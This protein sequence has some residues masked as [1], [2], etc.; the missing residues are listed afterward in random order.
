MPICRL[1]NKERELRESHIVP[2]FMYAELKNNNRQIL[3]INGS[4]KRGRTLV[5]DGAKEHLFCEDCE[6]HFNKH[7]ETPFR[8]YWIETPPLPD[9]W[10]DDNPRWIATDY[11]PFKLFHLSILFRASVSTLPIFNP[12][13]LG[14]H[15]E[16]IRLLLLNCDPG[17]Y[18]EYPIA[19]YAVVHHTT[20]QLVKMIS[21]PQV[22]R[23]GGKQCYSIMYGG[24][25]WWMCVASDRNYEFEKF[26]LQN[27]G[28]LCLSV[29]PWNE[30]AAVQKASRTLKNAGT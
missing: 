8:K 22:F 20:R 14:P 7:F 23:V 11:K 9:P 12:I 30:V 6:Q 27:D 28:R 3:A 17:E 25:E 18:C 2:K 16:K 29:F 15:E 21:Q 19:G 4:G 13:N 24:V 5:Q 26:A 1:C 10:N